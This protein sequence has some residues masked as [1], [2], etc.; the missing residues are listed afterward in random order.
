MGELGTVR[1]A[2]PE[3]SQHVSHRHLVEALRTDARV[4]EPAEAGRAQ[5]YA[6]D[7][8][9]AVQEE[10]PARIDRVPGRVN[11]LLATAASAFSLTRGL[12]PPGSP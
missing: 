4:A 9:E 12:L 10:N 6:D 3:I 7:L 8:A 2:I 5:E 1:A 11:A